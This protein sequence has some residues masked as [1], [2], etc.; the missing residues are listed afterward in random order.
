MLYLFVYTHV[1][2]QKPV[3]IFWRHALVLALLVESVGILTICIIM[4]NRH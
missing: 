3:L 1:I 4:D 2:I